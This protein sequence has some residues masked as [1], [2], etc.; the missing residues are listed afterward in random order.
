[1]NHSQLSTVQDSQPGELPTNFLNINAFFDYRLFEPRSKTILDV[2]GLSRVFSPHMAG[3]E[4]SRE[5]LIPIPSAVHQIY[6]R[7]RPTSLFRARAFEQALGTS[8]EIYVKS[9]VG[10]PSG[11]HKANSAYFIAYLCK[12]DGIRTMTTETTGN[13]GLALALAAREFG[14]DLVCFMDAESDCKRPD[15]KPAME[16]LGA[17]VVVVEQEKDPR[18]LLTLSADAAIHFTKQTDGAVYIF[19]SSYS[20]F[21]LPQS[22]I[23][24]ESR[25]QLVQI[26]RY[27]DVVIGS[28]GGGANLLGTASAFIVD[29]ITS[30]WP[31][32][33]ISGESEHCPIVSQGRRGL[34]SVDTQE[35]YP[36]LETYG[37]PGLN[38][39]DYIGGL[40]STIL[41]SAVAE[42]HARGVI[43]SRTYQSAQACAAATLFRQ[44]EGIWVALETGYQLAAVVDM[45]RNHRNGVILVN[46][47]GGAGDQTIYAPG[48]DPGALP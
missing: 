48:S 36:M 17:R 29:R 19:G 7:Y 20:Y 30:G 37:L 12:A 18:A 13:W 25:R 39:G 23:G 2:A 44:A 11:N 47:S 42:F 35:Y 14:L 26:D 46:I 8:C 40:G 34:Y 3:M 43:Q 16:Q 22:I 6:S 45:A 15:R 33:I 41:S 4:L 21:I 24:L 32:E 31:V 38:A 1:M 10:T 27:P 9:E 5:P 28:C